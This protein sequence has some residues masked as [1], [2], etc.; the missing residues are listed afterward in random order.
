[1]RRRALV[2]V[3]LIAACVDGEMGVKGDRRGGVT[4]SLVADED[5]ALVDPACRGDGC[6]VYP[7]PDEC[8][9]L[10]VRV[11]DDGRMCATCALGGRSIERCGGSE[12]GLPYDC[13]LDADGAD[14]CIRCIDLFGTEVYRTCPPEKPGTTEPD[15]TIDDEA[16]RCDSPVEGSC[17]ALPEAALQLGR[18]RFAEELNAILEEAGLWAEFAPTTDLAEDT[19]TLACAPDQGV[20]E[21]VEEEEPRR[22]T[23]DGKPRCGF[24]LKHARSRAK[25]AMEGCHPRGFERMIGTEVGQAS[26]ELRDRYD[27]VGSPI[28][29]DLD[30]DG[31]ETHWTGARFDLA[32][33][34]LP[35]AVA[36]VNGGDA[37]LAMD[38]DQNGRI[39]DGTELFGEATADDG[40]EALRPLD[41]DG[42]GA[43]TRRDHAFSR[44]R[45]W[46][47]D[48]D[49]RTEAGELRTLEE[50]GVVRI[51]LASTAG[52]VL[53]GAGSVLS[54]WSRFERSDGS[55]GAVCDVFFAERP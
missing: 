9:R 29:L 41:S 55:T 4:W 14:A 15:M 10:D 36:W 13:V 32:A 45:L 22:W 48:G 37:L 19:S 12:Q 35:S 34:G 5:L 51:D 17:D 28:V 50:A 42:D 27:C 11:R 44:L 53:D 24:I 43:L 38:R 7:N 25:D 46:V 52:D 54:L 18:E 2:A 21:P 20:E 16:P 26:L 39:E 6:P 31:I 23:R 1:M 47:D 30:G 40:F 49:A 33:L 3:I 8:L